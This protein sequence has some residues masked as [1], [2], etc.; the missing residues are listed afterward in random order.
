VNANVNLNV[1]LAVLVAAFSWPV[2]ADACSACNCG[3]PTLT[4]T[5]VEQPYRNRV[6]VGI[7][8]RLSTRSAGEGDLYERAVTLRSALAASWQ[9]H[10]RVTLAAVLPWITRYAAEGSGSLRL[11]KGL[12][13]LELQARVVLVQDRRFAPRHL[14]WATG[15]VKAPTGLRLRDDAGYP[16][17]D[18]Q[19]PGSGS[20]DPFLGATYG[21]FGRLTS[22][23]VSSSYRYTTPG[24]RGYRFGSTLGVSAALQ[25]QPWTLLAVA[26]GA[27]ARYASPDQLAGGGDAPNTGGFLLQLVPSLLVSP[28]TDLLIRLAVGVPVAHALYGVQSE[29]AQVVLA[30]SYDAH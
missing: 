7:E 9:P 10:A 28:R 29:G 1:A 20:W 2:R 30:V 8:E 17:P 16:Y 19:Q 5:G 22:L 24:P 25:V 27:D 4:A 12:G 21:Y 23:F 26:L 3:D 6:R 13:D 11:I 14:L 15:G 18:D